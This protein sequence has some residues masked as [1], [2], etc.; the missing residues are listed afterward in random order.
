MKEIAALYS[1]G[2]DSTCAVVLMLKEFDR[3][4][5]IT[6]RRFGLFHVEN[7]KT[8]VKKL[9]DKF[10]EKRIAHRVINIDKLF[11]KVSYAKNWYNLK[12]Y[13]FLLLSTCGL[14]KLAMHI[15]TA[16]YCLENNIKYVCDGA[17]KNVGLRYF[18]AQMPEVV[19]EIKNMYAQNGITYF[20]PVFDF[21]E[22]KDIGW[23]DKLGLEKLCLLDKKENQRESGITSGKILHKMLFFPG[24]NIKGTK[25]DRAMQARCFQFVLF[26]IF[27]YWYYLPTHGSLKYKVMTVNLYK[28][29]IEY[30][31]AFIEE[32]LERKNES[33]LRALM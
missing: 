2:T 29:K 7:V 24:E 11:R 8:N 3:V 30:F 10:G 31:K 15:R 27:L 14:C 18:P 32:Y 26:N 20:T 21:D 22:P 19:A 12:K 4:H 33:R 16:I 9:K 5:L 23:S 1:G 25:I 6:Y 28:E 17:N 13:G